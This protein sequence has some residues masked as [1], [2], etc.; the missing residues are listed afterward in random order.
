MSYEDLD[1]VDNSQQLAYHIPQITLLSR[2]THWRHLP[3]SLQPAKVRHI[4]TAEMGILGCSHQ[5]VPSPCAQLQVQLR[6]QA[7]RQSTGDFTRLEAQ[8]R[9]LAQRWLPSLSTL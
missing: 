5:V 9:Q 3:S 4:R 1:H 8:W 6:C 2:C 7:R